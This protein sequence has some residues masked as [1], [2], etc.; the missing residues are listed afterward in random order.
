L[1][2][3]LGMF[4]VAELVWINLCGQ[5]SIMGLEDELASL[6]TGLDKLD[7]VYV[8]HSLHCHTELTPARYKRIMKKIL[9]K[10][11]RARDE[12]KMLLGWLV[13]AKRPL[14]SH[15]VQ[16]MKSVNLERRR[17]EFDR[18]RF[19][20]NPKEL[21]ESLVDIREDGSIELV[22]LTAKV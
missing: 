13:C 6:P 20:V 21:C 15:E 5:T 18:R 11:D 12:A 2:L 9:D 17:I 16:T 19:R 14:K 8:F 22:H 4:L 7:E 3:Y 1:L 10:P